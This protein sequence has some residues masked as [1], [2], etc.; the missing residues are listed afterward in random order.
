MNIVK[1]LIILSVAGGGYHY[2]K[3]HSEGASSV[4]VEASITSESGFVSL[5]PMEGES[6]DAVLVVAAENCPHEDAQ[7]AD[8]LA[9]ALSEKGIPVVR[10]HNISFNHISSN[11]EAER[12]TSVMNGSLPIVFV[13]GR[14]KSNP[15]LEEVVAEYEGASQ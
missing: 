5:P 1:L 11:K 10:T 6:S 14:A 7:R 2:W 4:A 9:Q 12:I 8:N 13:D 15:T 3:A